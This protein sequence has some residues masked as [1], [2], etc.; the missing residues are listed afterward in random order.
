MGQGLLVGAQI[1]LFAATIH[2]VSLYALAAAG[3]FPSGSRQGSMRSGL[4]TF[5]LWATM[6]VTGAALVLATA[7]AMRGLPWPYAVLGSGIAVL[8]APLVLQSL[9]DRIVDS[10][11]G[12]FALAVASM[13]AGGLL[14]LVA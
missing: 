14:V 2:L 1:V 12:L 10:P 5:V 11:L 8:G 4:G 13:L 7:A 3:H 9:P 6:A